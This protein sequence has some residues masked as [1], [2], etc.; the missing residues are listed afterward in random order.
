MANFL[1]QL[2]AEYYS[3]MGYFVRTNVKFGL[4]KQG[5]YEGEM[6]VIAFHPE[7]LTLLHIE[8]SMDSDSWE[9]RRKKFQKKFSLAEP[10]Y[11]ELFKFEI[12]KI[13]KMAIIGLSVPEKPVD[14]WDIVPVKFIPY[15]IEEITDYLSQ[16][17]PLNHIVPENFP[18]L[19]AMQFVIHFNIVS[20]K[21]R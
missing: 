8:T 4:R 6:D 3:H 11:R 14:L 16:Y 10:Y 15:F 7:S 9:K 17:S 18:L 13:K 2:T 20:K 5:G 12:N 21:V 19:R 1:E